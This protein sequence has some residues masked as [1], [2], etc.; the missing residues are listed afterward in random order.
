MIKKKIWIVIGEFKGFFE[1]F[2]SESEAIRYIFNNKYKFGD[3]ISC[4]EVDVEFKSDDECVKE[5]ANLMGRICE[6]SIREK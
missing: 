2:N 1:S 6:I 3:I 5:F 4:V